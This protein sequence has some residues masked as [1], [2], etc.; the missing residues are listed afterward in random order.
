MERE[1][2]IISS[3]YK[4]NIPVPKPEYIYTDKK[5][6]DDDFY[7]MEFIEGETISDNLIARIL[8]KFKKTLQN[9]IEALVEIHMFDVVNSELSTLGKHEN[10][11]ERQLVRWSKQFDAQKVREI[12][13]LNQA[14]KM[15]FE[16]IPNQQGEHCSW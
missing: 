10:Y 16:N 4:N 1:F 3:L 7:I 8:M 9:L 15:L 2:R 14:T 5:I 13:E 6:S 12:N 11:I